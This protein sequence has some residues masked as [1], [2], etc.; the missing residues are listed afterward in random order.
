MDAA[1]ASSGGSFKDSAGTGTWS[2]YSGPAAL[3]PA[4]K[5]RPLKRNS[6]VVNNVVLPD[7]LIDL[8]AKNNFKLPGISGKALIGGPGEGS[9][10]DDEVAVHPGDPKLD[11][12]NSFLI[13]R[14]STESTGWYDLTGSVRDL[15]VMNDGVSIAVSWKDAAGVPATERVGVSTPTGFAGSVLEC[16][17]VEG[18]EGGWECRICLLVY[19]AF[20]SFSPSTSLL[21]FE[22]G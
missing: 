16:E 21:H 17:R 22:A 15:G 10:D 7:S 6:K 14:W 13:V 4:S 5:L 3:L 12:Q 19:L 8:G 20:L 9:P 18:A 2:V 11:P 1:G